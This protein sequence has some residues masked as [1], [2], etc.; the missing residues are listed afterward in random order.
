[1]G[2]HI[3]TPGGH[4]VLNFTSSSGT[5]NWPPVQLETNGQRA[6]TGVSINSSTAV[7]DTTLFEFRPDTQPLL[8]IGQLQ[9]AN[10][11]LHSNYPAY[12]I[13]NSLA[14]FHFV[15]RRD[16]VL[17]PYTMTSGVDNAPNTQMTSYYDVSWL[18]NRV[19]WDRYFV[20]SVPNRGTGTVADASVTAS[21]GVPDLLPNPRHVKYGT[22]SNEDLHDADKAAANLLLKGGFNINSTSEQAWRAVLGGINQ[23]TYIPESGSTATSTKLQAALPRFSKPTTPANAD[24]APWQGY[25]ALDETQIAQLATGIVSEIRN[26]GPFVSLADFVNRRLVDNTTAVSPVDERIKGV[27]QAALDALSSINTSTAPFNDAPVYPIFPVS[28]TYPDFDVELMQG[29]TTSVAPLSSRAS[30][31]PQVVTQADILSAIGGG[32]SA[33]SDTFTIRTYGEAQNPVTNEISGRAWCEAVV[34]R[35]PEFVKD[36][37]TSSTAG[38]PAVTSPASL[39]NPD[40]QKFGRRYKIISFRW[41]SSNDI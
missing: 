11:S 29:G 10:I 19:L 31:A 17:V 41:L 23:L 36:A 25:R 21:T 34:Q 3:A 37:A 6:S 13:G 12:P 16:Q 32:L 4:N 26:R 5:Q 28:S 1:A 14:D 39:Q 2:I 7:V 38:D 20:S 15:N 24:S 35:L 30:F 22:A 8:G 33:R 9:H 18:L 27:L 40:N